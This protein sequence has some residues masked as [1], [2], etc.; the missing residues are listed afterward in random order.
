MALHIKKGN[1]DCS[2]A[3]ESNL[4]YCTLNLDIYHMLF[5]SIGY[6]F[7]YFEWNQL[8]T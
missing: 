1:K 3:Y 4:K 6:L 5:W 8:F 7:T 2:M